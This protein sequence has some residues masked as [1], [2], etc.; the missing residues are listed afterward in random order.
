VSARGMS[1]LT[2]VAV[3]LWLGASTAHAAETIHQLAEQARTEARRLRGDAQLV[4]I[5]VPA[6]S[7][8]IGDSGWPDMSKVGPPA[9]L[10]FHHVSPSTRTQVR[11][12]VRA[13]LSAAQR[14][15]L[16]ERGVGPIQAEV[17]AYPA[18]PYTLP[19]PDNFMELSQAL[20]KAQEAGFARD[21]A[22]VN[23]HYGCGRV[24][25]AELHTYAIGHGAAGTP[26]WTFTFGQDANART[27]TRRVDGVTGRVVM[28]EEQ[29]GRAG[30]HP[31]I[32]APVTRPVVRVQRSKEKNAPSVTDL[33]D[34]QTVWVSLAARLNTRADNPRLCFVFV[35]RSTGQELKRECEDSRVSGELGGADIAYSVELTPR[36]PASV[37]TDVLDITGAVTVNGVTEEG[38][39]SVQ[40]HR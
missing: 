15:F 9:A 39:T 2:R 35:L 28:V 25:R 38:H 3:V 29:T 17:L 18:S 27:I 34:G 37:T 31:R 32:V 5:E 40:I 4:Q 23:V 8:A 19:V 26:I 33:G 24:V 30:D 6:F 12:V 13:D 11:V 10:V 21:C 22:G 14:R 1:W 16:Q 20:A 7:L 36:F